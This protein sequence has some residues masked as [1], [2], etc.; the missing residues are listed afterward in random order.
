MK[1]KVR[2]I[3]SVVLVAA[4]AIAVIPVVAS[5]HY[6]D[7]FSAYEPGSL[8][9][10][11]WG[12]HLVADPEYCSSY[13]AGVA[14]NP[15]P[16]GMGFRFYQ[17]ADSASACSQ[18]V[19]LMAY[20]NLGDFSSS[21]KVM[22]TMDTRD[23][24]CGQPSINF[25]L[26]DGEG[27]FGVNVSWGYYPEGIFYCAPD[28]SNCTLLAGVSLNPPEKFLNTWYSVDVS[29]TGQEITLIYDKGTAQERQYVATHEK[30][31]LVKEK[32]YLRHGSCGFE[33]E[34]VYFDDFSLTIPST[35]LVAIPDSPEVYGGDTISVG[36]YLQDPG[37]PYYALQAT[38]I[39]SPTILIPSGGTVEDLFDPNS[40][41]VAVNRVDAAAG[42]SEVAVSLLR[43]AE[44]ISEGGLFAT[45]TYVAANPGNT[46]AIAS[47]T[48]DVI[49]SDR[50]GFQLPVSFVGAE[51]TVLPYAGIEGQVTRQGRENDHS[52]IEVEA[53]GPFTYA[54][55]TVE[56][57]DFAF[58]E[59]R[60]AAGQATAVYA[61][62]ADSSSYLPTCKTADVAL[63]V[64]TTLPLTVLRGGDVNDHM[65]DN[66]VIDIGDAALLAE[67]FGEE[68]PPV[69]P[70]LELTQT[71]I[72]ADGVVNVQ[73]LAILGGNYELAGCQPWQ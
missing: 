17:R 59:V 35:D 34:E 40:R 5:T 62:T 72:N 47:I 26:A 10:P 69:D 44:A 18:S 66:L 15:N 21:V 27:I 70:P 2:V 43:P 29:F 45:L 12:N 71:D 4:A 48:C 58:T 39:T 1:S 68:V 55:S 60:A 22:K 11:N 37:E 52:N 56:S 9:E 13:V 25:P 41:Y 54:T 32:I 16:G 61:I 31:S 6:A 14:E 51:V 53:E 7:D 23:I 33:E 36:L 38:C 42:I 3:L 20:Q 8:G 63:G 19:D 73:D 64:T 50:D 57:G 24:G 49:L 67:H 28:A 30:A 46:A 65:L